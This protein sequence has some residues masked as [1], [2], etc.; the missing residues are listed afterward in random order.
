M[1]VPP[2]LD[3]LESRQFLVWERAGIGLRATDV[4]APLAKYK[5]D[6]DAIARRRRAETNKLDAVQRYAYTEKCRRGFLLRYFGDPAASDQC[7]GCDICLGT[8]RKDTETEVARP[9]AHEPGARKP[10]GER[11]R[12]DRFVAPVSDDPDLSSADPVLVGALRRLR[13][14]IAKSEHVPAYVVFPDRT[15]V[16]IAVRRP[17]SLD[18]LGA[19]HGVGPA[20]LE[21]YGERLLAVLREDNGTEAA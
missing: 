5:V 15:L 11:G 6:W 10:R 4:R 1:G 12:R 13:M 14:A 19:V 9:F 21:K 3:A 7:T 16:E 8:H 2:L 20:R 17:R 18:A